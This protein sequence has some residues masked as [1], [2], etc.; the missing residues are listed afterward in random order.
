MT[1]VR[2]LTT[3]E[4]QQLAAIP[5]DEGEFMEGVA[6]D[7]LVGETGYST[8][9]RRWARPTLEINGVW[10]GFQGDGTKTV[11]P[12]QAH[13]KIT[14]RLVADQRPEEIIAL[15]KEHID[16]HTLPGVKVLV[17]VPDSGAFPYLMPA[18]HPGNLAA[19]DV[20]R[21]LYG[22]EPFFARSGGSI[23]VCAM[24]LNSLGVYTVNF[25][26]GLNDER[27]HSPN[28]FFRLESFRKSQRA[29]CMLLHRLA[30]ST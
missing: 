25:G 14:C 6:I 27:L 3:E 19:R 22:K 30:E 23:P 4:R 28:E 11:L 13:A 10:G 12:S 9:E 15:L 1:A 2:P 7:A 24:F 21:Q 8:L 17:Q 29:Y 18:E 26:F 5:F 20:H 16:K